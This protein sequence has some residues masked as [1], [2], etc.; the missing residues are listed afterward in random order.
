MET[1][2][3]GPKRGG[4]MLVAL[5]ASTLALSLSTAAMAQTTYSIRAIGE[6]GCAV[7]SIADS[8]DVVGGCD[9][10]ATAW[11]AG[12]AT[13][14]GRLPNG[15]Y[16]VAAAIN[17]HGVAVGWGDNGDGRPRAELYRNGA[18]IDIDPSAANAYALYI[19]D[20]GVIVGNSLKGFGGC[21][22]WVAAIW[23][24]E[25][26][27]PG[28][29]RR[30]DLKPYPGGDGKARCEFATGANQGLQVVGGVQN[31]LFG[32]RG[33]F[34]NNDDKHTLTLLQ[35]LPGDW[36]SYAWAVNDLGQ[37]VGDSGTRPALWDND[38]AHTAI[39]LPLLPGDNYGSARAVNNLG[40]V[41]GWSAYRTPGTWE[42]G[43]VHE[44]I[45]RDGGVFELQSLLDPVSGD[46]W[47][48]TS[49]SA[50]NNA[51]EIVGVGLHN[52]Q[53]IPFVMTPAAP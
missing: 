23:T 51:G 18:V 38:G 12:V 27:K 11:Q 28:T 16:S 10:V 41:L 24:E 33:A 36:S 25:V 52:G 29:F 7:S 39:E 49:V 9:A 34:W 20:S 8:G 43:P 15:T 50:I 1:I 2:L 37:A 40:H 47:T 32:Q 46:G 4:R 22:S 42:V 6:P 53:V 14:L 5:L 13:S 35:P 30:T 44:V 17:G 3:D 21:N 48:I 26:G 19:N 31:S 45:W